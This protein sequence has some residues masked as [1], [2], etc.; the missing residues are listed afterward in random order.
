M[1]V[2]TAKEIRALVNAPHGAVVTIAIPGG[3]DWSN[4]SLDISE[5]P[6]EEQVIKVIW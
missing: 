2:V 6:D 1:K 3:G 4:T 5:S